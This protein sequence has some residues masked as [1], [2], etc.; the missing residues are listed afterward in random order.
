MTLKA[1]QKSFLLR[2]SAREVREEEAKLRA[3]AAVEKTV[4]K[5]VE[6]LEEAKP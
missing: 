6:K 2:G 3:P 4:E 5:T 1:L